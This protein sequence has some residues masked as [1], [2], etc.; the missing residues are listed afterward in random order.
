VFD[1]AANVSVLLLACVHYVNET[2]LA[3][4]ES[5]VDA[6]I[7]WWIATQAI[8]QNPADYRAQIDNL[9]PGVR[10]ASRQEQKRFGRQLIEDALAGR[11]PFRFG[12]L[13]VTPG[14]EAPP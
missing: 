10:T 8:V 14:A 12:D 11:L 6:F 13:G 4:P 2:A 1:E 3:Q 7:I 5:E 9:C